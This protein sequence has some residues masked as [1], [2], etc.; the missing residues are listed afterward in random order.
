MEQQ[1][2]FTALLNQLLAKPVT[3]LLERMG[4]HPE[5]PTHPIPNYLAMEILVIIIIMV[6][7]GMVAARLSVD[8]P[9][10]LQ[11]VMEI[12][13][14]GLASQ[15]DEII[16]HGGQQF[17]PLLF[18]LGIFI[19]LSNVFGEIPHLGTPTQAIYVTVGCALVAL[20]YYHFHGVRHH[21]VLGYLRTFMGP[22]LAIGP[23][24]FVIEIVSHLARGLS[25]SV[26]L[27]ANMLA[28]EKITEIIFE[29]ILGLGAPVI[30][31]GLHIFVGALQAYIFVLLT[32]IYLSGAVSEEH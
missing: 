27:F 30:F 12:A 25:L 11:Q 24:M 23:L 10:K 7:L 22:V 31:M 21:G 20:V 14:D 2:W 29:R 17:L 4:I 26:R 19:L 3:S 16:G 13:V 28:G 8:R 32:M 5:F 15:V 18:T 6:M 9:G 1:L